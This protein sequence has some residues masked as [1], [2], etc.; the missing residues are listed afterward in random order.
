[1]ARFFVDIKSADSPTGTTPISIGL[2]DESGKHTFYAEP[3]DTWQ[4]SDASEFTQREVTPHIEGGTSCIPLDTMKEHLAAW[5]EELRVS[6]AY[7]ALLTS[8]GEENL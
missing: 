2:V 8:A 1:M 5:I 7:I 4:L 6:I 3:S